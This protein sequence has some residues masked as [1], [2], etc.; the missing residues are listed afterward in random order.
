MNRVFPP[1][2]TPSLSACATAPTTSRQRLTGAVAVACSGA[3]LLLI[4]G[5][6]AAT[7]TAA[8]PGAERS[9]SAVAQAGGQTPPAAEPAAPTPAPHPRRTLRRLPDPEPAESLPQVEL[10]SQIVFQVL[11]SE[12]AAQRGQTGSATA[13]YLSLAK[14]T[15]DP[16]FARRATELALAERSLE[17]ALQAAQLW[18]ELSP[19]STLAAQTL[20]TLWLSTGKLDD[21]EP[22][23][24]A[25]LQQAR[26]DNAVAEFYQQ[27]QRT[28]LRAGDKARALALIER[29]AAAD[30]AVPEARLAVAALAAAAGKPERAVEES[31]K[32]LALKPGDETAAVTAAR[33]TTDTPGGAPAALKLLE[34]FLSR[35]PKAVEA[36]FQYARLLASQGRGDDARKQMELALKEE[37]DSPAILFSLAQIA[38][39]TRQL[40]VARDYLQRYLALPRT[41]PRDNSPALVFLAQIAEDRGQRA[42]AIGYLEQVTRG[43]QFLPAL[44]KR[45]LLM[46]KLGRV[47]EARE[48]L[49]NT[50]VPTTR[51]RVQLVAAEAQ[52]LREAGRYAEAFDVLSEALQRL[53]NDPDL[54]YDQA[55]AAEKLDKVDVMEASLRKLIE[56]RPD[57]A[58]AYNALGYSLADRNLRLEEAQQLIEKA[59]ELSPDDA[60]ILDSMGWVLY[61]RGKLEQALEYLQRAYRLRPEAEI[62]AHLGEVLWTI[63]RVAE[64]RELWRDARG[65]EPEN[66]TLK[67][68]LARLNVAL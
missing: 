22:L 46:G 24:A 15:R 66:Q 32:A 49:R 68:T 43:E 18:H 42:E 50:S 65:R 58:H 57:H 52:L 26:K 8:G 36:R 30:Q 38:Y 56:L 17:R 47:D 64:A 16:R 11:A 19:D 1:S 34:D 23:V 31:L 4:L 44:T 12:I 9:A 67:E 13:T 6:C 55:M 10:T 63:G 35:H 2:P 3:L 37:P 25:R 40:D 54:L 45:A 14:Q 28:L 7:G 53:P 60:H 21:A 41:V 29:V 33:Y 39:Q 59:L 51:E 27:L 5:G 20:E 61:R 62:A 48:L